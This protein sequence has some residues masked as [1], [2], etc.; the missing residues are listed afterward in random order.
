[1]EKTQLYYYLE[2]EKLIIIIIIMIFLLIFIQ[3]QELENILS[4]L[5]EINVENLNVSMNQKL[6][7][8]LIIFLIENSDKMNE[9]IL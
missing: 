3:N 2:D 1:L 8:L 9:N 5:V 6:L 7:V 4:V